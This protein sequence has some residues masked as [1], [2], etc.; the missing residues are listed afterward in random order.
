MSRLY[1]SYIIY[2]KSYKTKSFF[3]ETQNYW[4]QKD[5]ICILGYSIAI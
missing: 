2:F 5:E 4:F 1:N 3:L